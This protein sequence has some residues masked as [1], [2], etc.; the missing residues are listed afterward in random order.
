MS[1]IHYP[2][3]I[4]DAN[5]NNFKRGKFGLLDGSLKAENVQ[6]NYIIS[7]IVF[8]EN[9]P[10]LQNLLNENKG[11]LYVELNSEPY[12]YEIKDVKLEDEFKIEIPKTK[13]P[14]FFGAT[15]SIDIKIVATKNI[16]DY[17]N[18]DAPW[19]LDEYNFNIKKGYILAV[20]KTKYIEFPPLL[21]KPDGGSLISLKKNQDVS[22]EEFFQL[23]LS[24]ENI[25]VEMNPEVYHISNQLKVMD[26]QTWQL[27]LSRA[28]MLETLY[29]I[30]E[31]NDENNDA[32]SEKDWYKAINERVREL[33]DVEDI[34]GLRTDEIKNIVEKLLK[35]PL[36]Q[37]WR[38]L[39]EEK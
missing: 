14:Q 30:S 17:N 36:V 12:F 24:R 13:I 19:P 34:G 39:L 20:S 38:N 22:K 18:E 26:N 37:I 5:E 11:K 9:S 35:N 7:G 10:T 16:N 6:D 2:Y 25:L 28:I 23:A 1:N 3:P 31:E 8:L 15:I 4:F 32:Y 33:V 29:T 21:K 27:T